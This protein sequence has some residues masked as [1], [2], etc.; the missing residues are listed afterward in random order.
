MEEE[1]EDEDE[2]EEDRH[3]EWPRSDC[4]RYMEHSLALG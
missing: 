4:R 1:E 2:E 3:N